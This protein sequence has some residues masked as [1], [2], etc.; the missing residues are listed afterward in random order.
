ME[1]RRILVVDDED[2]ICGFLGLILGQA[3]YAVSVASDAVEARSKAESFKPDM[4]ITDL[5]LPGFH[6]GLDLCRWL[7]DDGRLPV[8]VISGMPDNGGVLASAAGNAGARE[9][10]S[11]PITEAGVLESVTRLLGVEPEPCGCE[12]FVERG[13]LRLDPARR[14]A[15]LHGR[16]LKDLGPKRFTL[17]LTLMRRREGAARAALLAE[18]WGQGESAKIVDVTVLRLRRRL[19]RAGLQEPA[20]AAIP[21]GYK[22]VL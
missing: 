14:L 10:L 1:P 2:E 9:F 5:V 12:P 3:G 11:K 20:I 6:N 19:A 18:V 7:C 8:L 15:W 22:L 21:G 13:P 16:L 17:L 4:L